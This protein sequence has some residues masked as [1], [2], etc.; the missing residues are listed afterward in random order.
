MGCGKTTAGKK[1][2]S[3]L[4]WSFIDL[5]KKIEEHA[6]MAIPEIFSEKGEDFFRIVEAE[7]LRDLKSVSTT[8]ISTGGGTPCYADNMDFMLENGLTIYLRLSPGQLQSRLSDSKGERPLIKNMNKEDLLGFI[9]EKLKYRE[10]WYNRA[11][12][13]IDGISL[14]INDLHVIVKSRINI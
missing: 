8:V 7:V 11:E 14:D 6:G 2:A 4:G 10:K 13:V 1:L 12:I 3:A 9:G 5:D